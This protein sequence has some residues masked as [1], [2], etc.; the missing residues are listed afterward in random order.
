[1]QSEKEQP[2][3]ELEAYD[4]QKNRLRSFELY[5]EYSQRNMDETI[6]TRRENFDKADLKAKRELTTEVEGEVSGFRIWLEETKG[7]SPS[8][9]R[10]HSASLKTL[11]FGLPTGVQ[12]AHLFDAILTKWTE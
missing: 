12:M 11:L 10:Y 7:L 9:A 6:R 1:M 3:V 8:T 4:T 5:E 2:I